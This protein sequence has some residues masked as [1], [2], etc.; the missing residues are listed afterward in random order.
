MFGIRN[1]KCEKN[2]VVKNQTKNSKYKEFLEIVDNASSTGNVLGETIAVSVT[3][4]ISVE[5]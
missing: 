5:K 2:S 4:S 3:I 1:G